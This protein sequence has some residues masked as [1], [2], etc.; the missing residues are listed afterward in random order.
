MVGQQNYEGVPAAVVGVCASLRARGERR[1][2]P[3]GLTLN[4]SDTVLICSAAGCC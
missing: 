1:L 2:F 3:A 4:I